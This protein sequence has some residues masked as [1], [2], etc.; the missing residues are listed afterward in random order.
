MLV[1]RFKVL[2]KKKKVVNLGFFIYLFFKQKKVMVGEGFLDNLCIELM[3]VPGL[4]SKDFNGG[5]ILK[6]EGMNS[7]DLFVLFNCFFLLV[8]VIC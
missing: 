5:T 4:Y 6:N 7:K 8:I 1:V 2:L 3:V